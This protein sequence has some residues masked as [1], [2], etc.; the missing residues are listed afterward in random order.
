ESHRVR[1]LGGVDEITA[2]ALSAETGAVAVLIST[3][4]LYSDVSPPKFSMI[5]RLVSLK[6]VPEIVWMDSVAMAGDDAPGILGLGL[7][8]DLKQLRV[9]GVR[10][11][12]TSLKHFLTDPPVRKQRVSAQAR[13]DEEP[14][15]LRGLMEGIKTEKRTLTDQSDL[16]TKSWLTRPPPEKPYTVEEMLQE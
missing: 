10:L 2:A 3:I 12:G 11:I 1:Y 15:T 13:R 5:S 6:G 8:D 14:F 16:L 9:K 7:I 4:E